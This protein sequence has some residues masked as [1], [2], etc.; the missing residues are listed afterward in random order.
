MKASTHMHAW[1]FLLSL[2]YVYRISGD[3]ISRKYTRILEF[4]A[5][6][7]AFVADF[8]FLLLVRVFTNA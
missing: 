4:T 5:R 2:M 6:M 3:P 1:T 8:V 7:Y